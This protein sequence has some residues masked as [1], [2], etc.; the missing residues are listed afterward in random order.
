VNIKKIIIKISKIF[1]VLIISAICISM[2]PGPKESQSIEPTFVPLESGKMRFEGKIYDGKSEISVKDVSFTGHISICGIRKETDS[3]INKLELTKIKELH[4]LK[5][6]YISKKYA[7]KEFILAKAITNDDIVVEGLLIPRHVVI[8]AVEP[9]TQME[10]A[11]FLYQISKLVL[12]KDIEKKE[13]EKKSIDK[14]EQKAEKKQ[15]L[16]DKITNTLT[17]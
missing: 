2:S 15:T 13:L 10:K 12:T 7:D 17:P 14:T 8:C 1:F 4:I 9:E 16:F 6:T 11:W 5:P 3:S